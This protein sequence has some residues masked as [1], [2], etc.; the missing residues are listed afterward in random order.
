MLWTVMLSFL[1]N[2][3][4]FYGGQAMASVVGLDEIRGVHT[5]R[6]HPFVIAVR[7]A[8]P[9]D[10]ILQL[11]GSS[12]LLVGEDSFYLL[13]FL[14]INHVWWRSGEVGAMGFGLVVWREKGCMERVMYPPHYWECQLVDDWGYHFCDTKGA[15]PFW[16]Y[17]GHLVWQF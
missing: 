16:V 1:A 15:I 17:L 13:F 5:L 8:L 10:Q 14:P 6:P 12:D 3:S 4:G 2:L 9:L 11:L 7:K